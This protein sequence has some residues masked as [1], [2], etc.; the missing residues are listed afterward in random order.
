[1]CRRQRPNTT[2]SHQSVLAFLSFDIDAQEEKLEYL[3]E[4]SGERFQRYSGA[5]SRQR[6]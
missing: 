2:R 4:S 3:Q 1:M 6:A 5:G